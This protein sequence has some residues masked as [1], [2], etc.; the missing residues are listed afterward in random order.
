MQPLLWPDESS[1][2]DSS[3]AR[4]GGE[5]SSSSESDIIA[6][7]V[8]KAQWL[9]RTGYTFGWNATA[10]RARRR[11]SPEPQIAHSSTRSSLLRR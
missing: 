5:G 2:D 10:V 8:A 1:D 3:V 11:S 4:G 9:R 7:A 6:L